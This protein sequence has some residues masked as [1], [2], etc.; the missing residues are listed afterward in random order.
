MP[1]QAQVYGQSDITA[2]EVRSELELVLRSPAFLRSEKLQ[3]FLK[4][5][6]ETTLQGSAAEINEYLIG[7]KVFRRG[8]KY[9]PSEDSIVRRHAHA[10]RQ[11][12]QEYYSTEGAGHAIRIEMP[13]GRYVPV[14]RRRE[15]VVADVPVPSVSAPAIPV[16]A[17]PW[18]WRPSLVAAAAGVFA[19]GWCAA[20]YSL[21]E[22]VPV[23]RSK[24]LA[25]V[26]DIWAPWIGSQAVICFSNPTS[27]S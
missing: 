16:E 10:M 1:Q 9:N 24:T 15:D 18:S 20:Y 4:F 7:S 19:L 6:C 8:E 17:P 14:F 13:V 27:V 12:L 2:D 3:A 21:R 25:E 5:V 26:S 22:T 11:K 23:P